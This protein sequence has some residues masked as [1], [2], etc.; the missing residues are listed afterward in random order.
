MLSRMFPH[1]PKLVTEVTKRHG[2]W[3][4]TFIGMNKRIAATLILILMACTGVGLGIWLFRS[5]EVVLGSLWI[6]VW[7]WSARVYAIWL[8]VPRKPIVAEPLASLWQR[9]TLAI[10]CLLAAGVCGIGAYIWH[11]WPD[12]WQAGL[13]FIL[14]GMIVLIP[15]TVTEIQLRKKLLMS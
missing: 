5:G 10:V 1:V 15:V 6:A 7:T 12:E 11:L 9:V 14:F 2:V 13:V 8:I 4:D 3:S